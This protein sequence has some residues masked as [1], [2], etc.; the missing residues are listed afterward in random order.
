MRKSVGST[1]RA[2]SMPTSMRE[3]HGVPLTAN[4]ECEYYVCMSICMSACGTASPQMPF[5]TAFALCRQPHFRLRE[6]LARVYI[7]GQAHAARP[8]LSPGKREV[9][10]QR[11]KSHSYALAVCSLHL[12]VLFSFGYGIFDTIDIQFNT[13]IPTHSQW[14]NCDAQLIKNSR[15]QFYV[16]RNNFYN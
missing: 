14:I 13:I 11:R 3:V 12:S 7:C 4:C 16:W 6:R 1:W 8:R 2:F 9:S 5:D 10:G 15:I